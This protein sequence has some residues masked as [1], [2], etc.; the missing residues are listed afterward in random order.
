MGGDVAS[1]ADEWFQRACT[2][3]SLDGGHNPWV[4]PY[5]NGM[6][7]PEVI[8]QVNS[9]DSGHV[10]VLSRGNNGRENIMRINVPIDSVHNAVLRVSSEWNKTADMIVVISDRNCHI[11]ANPAHN[12]CI[13]VDVHTKNGIFRKTGVYWF[14]EQ[15]SMN[16]Y[17][18]QTIWMNRS[19]NGIQNM[20]DVE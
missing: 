14:D 12:H 5:M 11:E 7:T 9:S 17:T 2:H 6:D 10:N 16:V 3:V 19:E 8:V 13:V 1:R 4:I 15:G 18:P 20:F